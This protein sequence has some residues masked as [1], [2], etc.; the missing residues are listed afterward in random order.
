MK[1]KGKSIFCARR[2]ERVGSASARSS[3]CVF[4]HVSARRLP[5]QT[6]DRIP[7]TSQRFAVPIQCTADDEQW[8]SGKTGS[9]KKFD[10]GPDFV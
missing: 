9:M 6:F 8:D 2:H 3:H 7:S 1:R 10:G 5:F 4:A